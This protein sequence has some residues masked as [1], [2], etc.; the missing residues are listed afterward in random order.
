MSDVDTS[1][2]DVPADWRDRLI[3]ALSADGVTELPKLAKWKR[4]VYGF[5]K[6]FGWLLLVPLSVII[7]IALFAYPLFNFLP[8]DTAASIMNNVVTLFL[9]IGLWFAFPR[10][11]RAYRELA[12]IKLG[13]RPIE[14]LRT[15]TQPP[16]LFLRSFNFD[17]ISSSLPKWQ[18]HLPINVGMPTAELDL[19][20]MIWRHAP[21]LAIGRPGESTPPAGAVRFYVRDDI[22]QKTIEAIVPSCQLVVWTTG[23]T[24]GLRWEIKHLIESVPPRKLLMWLHVNIGKWTPAARDA[25]WAKFLDTY[26]TVFPKALPPSADKVRFIAFEN[27]WTPIAIPGPGYR[28]SIWE[29][30]ASWPGN[31]GLEP[32]LKKRLS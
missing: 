2:R 27:D 31:Y 26:R 4:Y 22:W 17:S 15:A 32:I 8:P 11:Q 12:Q 29:M 24:E 19:V 30:I 9:L 7:G 23:H 6:L 10:L 20:Q 5:G 14:V 13:H 16:V 18:Q 28:P 21:V 1:G 25:E 3:A